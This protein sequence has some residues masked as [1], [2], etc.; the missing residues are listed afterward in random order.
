MA[1]EKISNID[2]HIQV[3]LVRILAI[4]TYYYKRQQYKP[5]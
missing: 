2:I 3:L 5:R 4:P 1:K